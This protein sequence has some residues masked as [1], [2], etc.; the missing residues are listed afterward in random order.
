MPLQD[1]WNDH[2][3]GSSDDPVSKRRGDSMKTKSGNRVAEKIL[4]TT[5]WKCSVMVTELE[6][7]ET[8]QQWLLPDS[9]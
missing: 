2:V 4:W 3:N 7:L 5:G 1:A 9:P 6:V 8:A